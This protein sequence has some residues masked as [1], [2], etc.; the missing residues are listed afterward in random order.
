MINYFK[1]IPK[2]FYSIQFFFLNNKKQNWLWEAWDRISSWQYWSKSLTIKAMLHV[3][4]EVSSDCT[5]AIVGLHRLY[6]LCYEGNWG[7]NEVLLRVWYVN[8]DDPMTNNARAF[9]FS[10][11]MQ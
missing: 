10:D 3:E 1:N 5:W 4:E 6:N 2:I 8:D 11:D 7:V 9:A